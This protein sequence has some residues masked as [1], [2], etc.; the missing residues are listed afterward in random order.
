MIK[1][2][3]QQSADEVDRAV[4]RWGSIGLGLSMLTAWDPHAASWLYVSRLAQNKSKPSC[5]SFPV[6]PC[7]RSHSLHITSLHSNETYRRRSEGRQLATEVN[8]FVLVEVLSMAELMNVV[9]FW[10]GGFSLAKSWVLF[11]VV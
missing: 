10:G 2:E 1:I 9:F 11:G 4:A 3:G 8:G 5:L 7:G 6:C